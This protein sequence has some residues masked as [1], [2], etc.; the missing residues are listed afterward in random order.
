MRKAFFLFILLCLSG[1]VLSQLRVNKYEM[2]IIKTAEKL[3]VLNMPFGRHEVLN[4]VGDSSG[5]HKAGELMVDLVFTDYPSYAS[6]AALN[7]RRVNEFLKIFPFIRRNQI[8][9]I[10]MIRQMDGWEKEQAQ[11]M[12]HG[13]VVRYREKQNKETMKK[14]LGLLTKILTPV[15]PSAGRPDGQIASLPQKDP[16]GGDNVEGNFSQ[17]TIRRHKLFEPRELSVS[18]DK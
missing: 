9:R 16:V 18:K 8:K 6:L 10:T 12:F 5:L 3:V 7:E 11:K 4:I 15:I 1:T 2:P 17:T 14:D 13:M